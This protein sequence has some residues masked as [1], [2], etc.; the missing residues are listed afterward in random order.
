[1]NKSQQ[2]DLEL[3]A[4]AES[5][6]YKVDALLSKYQLQEKELQIIL[7]SYSTSLAPQRQSSSS[8]KDFTK[9]NDQIVLEFETC[10]ESLEA[11]GGKYD[12]SGVR[13]GHIIR[14][15]GIPS[16]TET[17]QQQKQKRDAALHVDYQN[18]QYS[19][20]DLAEKYHISE[21]YV[22]QI[23]MPLQKRKQKARGYMNRVN[24]QKRNQ[25]I[26]ATAETSLYTLAEIGK[27]YRLT[28]QEIFYVLKKSGCSMRAIKQERKAAYQ[29][30]VDLLAQYYAL[31]KK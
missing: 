3:I 28:G 7:R 29:Q 11:I 18:K 2:R 30:L 4:D 16:R 6:R 14:K 13:I 27:M 20:S 5:G 31:R 26:V 21:R 1:M 15:R 19:I 24:R 9:R 10:E 8:K 25:E 22:R 12:L 23:I 17:Q